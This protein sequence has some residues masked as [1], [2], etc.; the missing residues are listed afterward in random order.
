MGSRNGEGPGAGDSRHE[1]SEKS[2][3]REGA[4]VIATKEHA[5]QEPLERLRFRIESASHD[6]EV[7]RLGLVRR[8][9]REQM[10]AAR[11]FVPADHEESMAK[12]REE[13]RRFRHCYKLA[14]KV[15]R[16]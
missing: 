6:V 11:D 3:G 8:V 2:S 10:R 13:W 9:R 15:L 4:S 7:W 16:P 5:Q 1:A 14:A 12:L